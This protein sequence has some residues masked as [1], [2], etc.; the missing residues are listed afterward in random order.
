[1][2][3]NSEETTPSMMEEK[4]QQYMEKLKVT[5]NQVQDVMRIAQRDPEWIKQRIGRMTASNY[6][7]AAGHNPYQFS[8]QP[9]GHL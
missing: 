6:G 3:S 2:A 4:M 7:S 9:Y 1:M 5:P 8:R